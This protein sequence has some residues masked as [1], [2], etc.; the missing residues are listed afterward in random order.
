MILISQ[1]SSFYHMLF[2]A[3]PLGA[4]AGAIDVSLNHYLA[5]H[6]KA[7]HMN[8][9][10]SFYG[11]GVTMG[12]TI[13]AY[14]LNQEKWRLGYIIVGSIL[15]GI[16]A[17]VLIS[18]K[19]WKKED[20]EERQENHKKVT[21][22]EILKTKGALESI[23]IFLIYVHIESLSGV[24]VASY[25]FIEKEVN[26][27]TAALFTTTF[28]LALTVGR[29]LSGFLSSKVT[30][31]LLVRIGQA[32]LLISG[33]LMFIQF[34]Q[35]FIYFFIVFLF[36]LGAGPIFPNMMYMNSHVFEKNK[37]SKIISLQMGIGYMGFGIL[38]PLVGLF[39]GK[40]SIFYYPVFITLMSGLLIIITISYRKHTNHLNQRFQE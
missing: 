22:Q 37:L 21:L 31:N 4:G 9:L 19:L 11:V 23:L 39:F 40:V 34:Q 32:L 13:M 38:T 10:H 29:I 15:I 14:T 2:F 1:V 12:P 20:H 18:F 17:I 27:A 25:F 33:L 24:W 6:Y 16:A 26:Y 5:S 7:K 30:P 35:V 8:Y 3:L 28:Y 36:G